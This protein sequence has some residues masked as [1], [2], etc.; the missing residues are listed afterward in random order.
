MF[1]GLIKNRIS[2]SEHMT[3][4]HA[5]AGCL[6]MLFVLQVMCLGTSYAQTPDIPALKEE[7]SRQDAIY[8]GRGAELLK[9]YVINR[10][11]TSY[12]ETMISG[13][14]SSLANLG[15]QDR[16]L[17]VGAGEGHAI[18]D[19]YAAGESDKPVEGVLRSA[20]RASAVALSIEDRRTA[21]WYQT[22]GV[23]E[24]RKIQYL[25][26]RPLRDY[27]LQEL[28]RFQ[29]I[30][31]LLGGF[32]YTTNLDRYMDRA[33]RLL[34]TGGSLYTV[35]QDVHSAE[36]SNKPYY[37]G[38]PYLTVLTGADG[39]EVKVCSWLKSIACVQVECELRA[40]WK[41]PIEVYHVQK[42]CPDVRVPALAPVHF[43]AGTPPERRF[44][45]RNSMLGASTGE[46]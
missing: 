39:A 35:L 41:P 29:V 9:G 13:F 7:L 19:Y 45:L 33:L 32:S 42:V 3:A 14:A 20:G 10:A 6:S 34:L 40:D 25:I 36:G 2:W 31:D 1:L 11:L 21:R 27:S 18:L 28:G 5:R 12:K 4:L 46:R 37:A 8:Q 15:V 44:A 38:A 22:A 23:L 24:D 17:D 30:T 43:V 26:G 16:W